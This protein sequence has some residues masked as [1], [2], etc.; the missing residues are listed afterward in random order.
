MNN[1]CS[2]FKNLLGYLI[3]IV[4]IGLFIAYIGLL[5]AFVFQ[6]K[7][8]VIHEE[9][10]WRKPVVG[11]ENLQVNGRVFDVN[12]V[13]GS[14]NENF[15][16]NAANQSKTV[17]T[18]WNNYKEGSCA[19]GVISLKLGTRKFITNLRNY[20]SDRFYIPIRMQKG[21]VYAIFDDFPWPNRDEY[22]RYRKTIAPDYNLRDSLWTKFKEKEV[23]P[24]MFPVSLSCNPCLLTFFTVFSWF[25]FMQILSVILYVFRNYLP[26]NLRSRL[27]I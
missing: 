6:P 12:F 9:G 27:Q 16:P 13:E 19:T 15:D 10:N 21:K 5:I 26:P 11:I 3:C 20:K 7:A 25:L 23:P 2:I 17:P 1:V 24:F 14:F 22:R 8:S 4:T 18:F